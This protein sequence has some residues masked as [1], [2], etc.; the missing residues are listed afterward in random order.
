MQIKSHNQQ[1]PDIRKLE[2]GDGDGEPKGAVRVAQ[3]PVDSTAAVLEA[4]QK[5]SKEVE[6]LKASAQ[7]SSSRR[8]KPGTKGTG[9][10]NAGPVCCY[11]CGQVG[12]FRSQCTTHP[13][14]E[15]SGTDAKGS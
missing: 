15:S 12:H 1:G 3:A 6:G 7:S 2:D 13:W 14:S 4:I 9:K 11:G 10:P 8:P 5:L